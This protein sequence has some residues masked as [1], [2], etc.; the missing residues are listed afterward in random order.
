MI[1]NDFRLERNVRFDTAL[2][3]GAGNVS[4]AE[5]TPADREVTQRRE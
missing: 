3:F 1:I 4:G 5:A 2:P